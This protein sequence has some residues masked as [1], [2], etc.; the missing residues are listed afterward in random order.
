[1]KNIKKIIMLIG[2]VAVFS[3][4]FA[5]GTK[6]PV[7][8]T[9]TKAAPKKPA[10]KPAPKKTTTVEKSTTVFAFKSHTK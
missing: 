9:T 1:M 7:K 10:P 8:K 6:A 3:T 2:I 5:A 4:S